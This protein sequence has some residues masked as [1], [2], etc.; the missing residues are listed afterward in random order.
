M[1]LEYITLSKRIN[2]IAKKKNC[3]S[4]KV[5]KCLGCG[6]LPLVTSLG[7]WFLLFSFSKVFFN[8]NSYFLA[9]PADN[10]FKCWLPNGQYLDVC[11]CVWVCVYVCN[12][13]GCAKAPCIMTGISA[14]RY[15]CI[16]VCVIWLKREVIE[17]NLSLSLVQWVCWLKVWMSMDPFQVE[18]WRVPT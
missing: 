12:G 13:I 3:W 10:N 8:W 2:Q 16:C 7:Q 9:R 15:Q 14:F 1:F 6:G 5:I 18:L 11:A 4:Q 17:G